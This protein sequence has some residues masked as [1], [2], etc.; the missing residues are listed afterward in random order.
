[1]Q[2]CHLKFQAKQI[3]G[4]RKFKGVFETNKDKNTQNTVY[5]IIDINLIRL[6]RKIFQNKIHF[7]GRL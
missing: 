4:C 6:K 3:F 1:M 7:K 5:Q 2:F